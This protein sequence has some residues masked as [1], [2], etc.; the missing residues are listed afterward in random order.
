[1]VDPAH[2]RRTFVDQAGVDL[3]ERRASAD[4]RVGILGAR[5]AAHADHRRRAAQHRVEPRGGGLQPTPAW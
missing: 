4:A 1:M 2:E 5:D 3:H